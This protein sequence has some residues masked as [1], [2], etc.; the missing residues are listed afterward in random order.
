[1][2]SSLAR[3]WTLTTGAALAALC[4]AACGDAP[5]GKAPEVKISTPAPSATAPDATGQPAPSAVA[6]DDDVNMQ[7]EGTT[8]GDLIPAFTSKGS[9]GGV[10]TTLASQAPGAVTV[11]CVG[12][13]EC[14]YTNKY[15]ERLQEIEAAYTAK[16]TKFVWLYSNRTESDA[17][18]AEWHAEKKLG[19]LFVIDGD[20]AIA[21]ALGASRTP[22]IVVTDAKG[23][24]TYRGA[25]DDGGG[26]PKRAK[27]QYLTDAIDATLTGKAVENAA[28]TPA[29]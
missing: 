11:Y 10:A 22:E 17:R 8:P 9:S 13:T 20:A 28:T 18:K 15:A 26:D 23:T 6:A 2:K 19:G 27:I 7:V 12:S 29:G 24:I 5:T 1:M 4:L 21:R 25:V 16:G 3:T 14:P